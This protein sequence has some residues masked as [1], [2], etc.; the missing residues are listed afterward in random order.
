MTV[1]LKIVILVYEVDKG[2]SVC[3]AVYVVSVIATQNCCF[4]NHWAQIYE[5][6]FVI[7]AI[8]VI[9]NMLRNYVTV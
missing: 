9:E 6:M 5:G 1:K 4:I 8:T 2:L 7:G 3:N